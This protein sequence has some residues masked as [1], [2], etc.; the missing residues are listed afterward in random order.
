MA[1][2]KAA[3]NA[4]RASSAAAPVKKPTTTKITT[5]KAVESRPTRSASARRL[6][7]VSR[8]NRA[9]LLPAA[10][11]EFVGTF[12]LATV[13]VTQQNQPIAL[14]FALIGIV[15]VVGGMSG[16]HI[17]PIATVGAWVTG[18]IRSPRAIAYLVAQVLGAMLALVVLNAFIGQAAEVSQQAVRAGQSAPSLFKAAAIPSGKEWT[19]LFAELL[20]TVILGF[21]YASALRVVRDKVASSLTIGAGYFLALVISGTT[22]TYVSGSVILNPATAISL[23]ALNFSSVWSVAIYVV[24]SLIGGVLGFALYELLASNVV[25]EEVVA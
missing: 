7:F 19:L 23:Q 11:A 18:K 24:T 4:K 12:L 1:T 6:A 21:A 22:A 16:A 9:P 3:S 14:L 2:K 17:N 10:V 13:A 20:G 25:D 8:F 5:V 15:L